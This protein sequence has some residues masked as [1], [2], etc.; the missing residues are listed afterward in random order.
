MKPLH[1]RNNNN[2]DVI[3]FVKDNE[4]NFMEGNVIKYITRCRK[5]GT[6]LKDLEKALDYIQREIEH[7]RKEELKKL[8]E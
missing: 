1:Y 3:D 7:I 2:Y 5:K 4:L 8:E 6:H